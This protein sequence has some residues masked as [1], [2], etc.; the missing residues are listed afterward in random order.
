MTDLDLDIRTSNETTPLKEERWFRFPHYLVEQLPKFKSYGPLAVYLALL[1]HDNPQRNVFPS[2]KRLAEMT[3]LTP[4]GVQKA[5][6]RLKK[7]GL[8]AVVHRNRTSNK[9]L[10]KSVLAPL[11]T[12]HH[13]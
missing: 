3:G 9:Y 6:Q 12:K 2:I 4:R 10:L 5:I 1:S 7:I 13:V 8:V 11:K